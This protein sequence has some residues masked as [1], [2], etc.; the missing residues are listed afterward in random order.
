FYLDDNIRN[1]GFPGGAP[2]AFPHN[3]GNQEARDRQSPLITAIMG[4]CYGGPTWKASVSDIVVQVKG[5]IMAV[6]GPPVLAAAT[7]ELV[8]PE[9]L[10]GWKI[11][12]KQTGLVDF[13]AEDDQEALALIRKV[14]QYLPANWQESPPV[15]AD[16]TLPKFKQDSLLEIL[17]EDSKVA[18]DMH[19]ILNMIFDKSSLLELKPFYDS[20]LITAFARLGGRVVGVLANNPKI[21]AGA[22]GPGACE[23]ASSFICLCDSYHIPLCFI[24]DTPGFYVSKAAE[25]RQM[26]TK[27]MNFIKTLEHSTVPR[28][29]L[30]IRKSYGMAHCNMVGA[31]MGADFL[32][33]WP[34]AD[35]SF[36]SPE[37]ALQVVMGRRLKEA[38]KP[39]TIRKAFLEEMKEMNAPWEAARKNLIDRIIDPRDTRKELI[40]AFQ[41]ASG[42]GP[43][44]GKSKRKM[45]SWPKMF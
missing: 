35:I 7:G 45:A 24:H 28:I 9:E 15:L 11:H 40:R 43:G 14:L 37:V 22:M 29:S 19:E 20:S 25:E 33:A 44:G 8:N 21:N 17:P 13:F 26:P 34:Q 39:E 10:G 27:I 32:L 16:V 42:F 23:K 6:T 1:R 18:Y 41:V 36:M 5:S 31:N 12:A 38:D 30:I 4:E 2:V 3:G